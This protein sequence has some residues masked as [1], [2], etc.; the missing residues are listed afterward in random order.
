M[1]DLEKLKIIL[2][3]PLCDRDTFYTP[4]Q[5]RSTLFVPGHADPVPYI[6]KSAILE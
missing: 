6:L 5:G 1:T 3:S 2:D 4:L